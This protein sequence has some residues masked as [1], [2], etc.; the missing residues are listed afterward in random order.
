MNIREEHGIGIGNTVGRDIIEEL[1][2]IESS[3]GS[4]VSGVTS[5]NSRTGAVV[6]EEGDYDISKITGLQSALDLKANKE[7]LDNILD[8]FEVLSSDDIDKILT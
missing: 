4:T 5:F 6:P 3:G 1:K 7:D 2:K 8:S